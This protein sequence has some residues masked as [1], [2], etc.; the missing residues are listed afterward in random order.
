MRQN[1]VNDMAYTRQKS[2]LEYFICVIIRKLV[3]R[4]YGIVRF[5]TMHQYALLDKP[6]MR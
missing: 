4:M 1:A 5:L 6:H 3:L 2:F